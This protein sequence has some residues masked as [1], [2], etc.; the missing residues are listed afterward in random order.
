VLARFFSNVFALF[1]SFFFAAKTIGSLRH[2]CS[3]V[4]NNHE[5]YLPSNLFVPGPPFPSAGRN[6]VDVLRKEHNDA[7]AAEHARNTVSSAK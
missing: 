2:L 3:T 4:H 6:K 7:L 5:G 1:F